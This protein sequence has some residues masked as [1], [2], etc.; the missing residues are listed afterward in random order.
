MEKSTV[1]IIAGTVSLFGV[2]G[3]FGYLNDKWQHE[4]FPADA[5]VARE[6]TTARGMASDAVVVGLAA[7]FVDESGLVHTAFDA[8]RYYAP[9]GH[10]EMT[11]HSDSHAAGGGA[12]PAM[13]GAPA[14]G[15][16]AQVCPSLLVSARLRGN[17]SRS[18]TIDATWRDG[19]CRKSFPEPVRCSIAQVWQRA[20]DAGAPHPALADIDLGPAKSGTGRAWTFKIIDRGT[21]QV[22]FTKGFADDC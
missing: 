18:L 2:A 15:A 5:Y 22:V 16:A 1:V 14:I 21:K 8:G 3:L 20:I 7:D 19:D 11:F 17:R 9:G 4:P 13:L 10:L 12:A 6:T